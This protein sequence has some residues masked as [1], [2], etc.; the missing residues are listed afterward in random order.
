[1]LFELGLMYER[2]ILKPH[3]AWLIDFLIP[4]NIIIFKKRL[5][6]QKF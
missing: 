1:M 5:Q 2:R 6:Y 3:T 4:K